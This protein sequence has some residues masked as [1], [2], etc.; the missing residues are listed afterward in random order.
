MRC[1]K[2]SA[3][4]RD[5]GL[6]SCR[7]PGSTVARCAPHSALLPCP[8]ALQIHQPM[9]HSRWRCVEP[10][11]FFSSFLC[12]T[13]SPHTPTTPPPHT[14]PISGAA[15]TAREGTHAASYLAANCQNCPCLLDSLRHWGLQAPCSAAPHDHHHN[16]I[17]GQDAGIATKD[18]DLLGH[19]QIC[20]HCTLHVLHV[21]PI[22]PLYSNLE[23]GCKRQ[24]HS[25]SSSS[26]I[27]EHAPSCQPQD[28]VFPPHQPRTLPCG[29]DCCGVGH[30]TVGRSGRS[31]AAHLQGRPHCRRK[32][33]RKATTSPACQPR[34]PFSRT[35]APTLTAPRYPTSNTTVRRGT[36]RGSAVG[37]QP[38]LPCW[39]REPHLCAV[40]VQLAHSVRFDTLHY[41]QTPERHCSPGACLRENGQAICKKYGPSRPSIPAFSIAI[42]INPGFDEPRET[43]LFDFSSTSRY[44]R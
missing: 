27:A 1:R 19:L 8:L 28:K 11:F 24:R 26:S 39:L 23:G 3:S 35:T 22:P 16:N 25:C 5:R 41:T 32:L 6:V 31:P 10:I 20:L 12:Y 7:R 14:S 34:L 30:E 2:A 9:L 18:P 44:R 21:P 37:M 17:N 13:T 36:A 33:P 29:E 38:T 4:C 15:R 43:R 40:R 42:R